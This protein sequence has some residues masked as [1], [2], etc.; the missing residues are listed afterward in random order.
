[1][2][3]FFS[4]KEWNT[5]QMPFISWI[6]IKVK[7]DVKLGRSMLMKTRRWCRSAA[8]DTFSVLFFNRLLRVCSNE[9]TRKPCVIL[10]SF[11]KKKETK[12]KWVEFFFPCIG[13]RF[14]KGKREEIQCKYHV[15]QARPHVKSL[16]FSP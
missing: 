1:M 12:S 8:G 10:F 7:R 6:V 13:C 14:Y 16:S 11:Y 9:N 15:T 5:D 3:W 4:E 2:L